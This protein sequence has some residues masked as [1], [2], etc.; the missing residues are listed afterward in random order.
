MQ[1][2]VL[3]AIISVIGSLFGTITGG[4][5]V[6]WGNRTLAVRKERL[7][8]RTACLL[9]ATELHAAQLTVQFA[10]D[11]HQWWRPDDDIKSE[12]WEK[13][14]HV[15]ASHLSYG[16][17]SD[18]WLAACNLDKVN[19]LAA[20]PRPQGNAANLLLPE[21]E[22]ALGIILTSFQNGRAVLVPHLL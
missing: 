13:Y 5:I 2:P 20:A 9:I 22:H 19:V 14:K 16:V 17:W 4:A 12:A 10:L 21:T 15:L 7:E 11:N 3:V 18:V 8:L 6:V 1:L